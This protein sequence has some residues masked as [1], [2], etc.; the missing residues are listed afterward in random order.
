MKVILVA[1]DFSKEAENAVEYAGAAAKVVGAK[2]VLFHLYKLSVHA[3]N[4]RLGPSTFDDLYNASQKK[5]EDRAKALAEKYEIKTVA[6][7][8]KDDFYTELKLS[9]AHF[10]A[11]ILVLGMPEKSLEL[12]ML[13]NTTTAVINRLK[14]PVLAIPLE[15]QFEGIKTILF[16]ADVLR[17]VHLHVLE[18]VK[19]VAADF[20]AKQ[21]EI[22]HVSE[23]VKE[24]QG[25]KEE[26]EKAYGEDGSDIQ[27]YYKNVS[28]NAV[29]REIQ[30]ELKEI[31]AD[32]LI[33]VPNKYGFWSSLIH[34]SKT[35]IMALNSEVP[36]LS[37]PL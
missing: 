26:T 35:R 2:V 14:V 12:D 34:R 25:L 16:A 36:L 11:D 4:S 27:Y 7:W 13:G 33:M 10:Q 6:D 9:L 15:V 22:F 21:V 5:L 19:E 29:I 37:L 3:L 23:K 32:M 28:S 20:G 18:K 30:M 31:Q 24:L 1:T 8:H 17:G